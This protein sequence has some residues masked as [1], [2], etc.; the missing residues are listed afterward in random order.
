MINE[1]RSEEKTAIARN[2]LTKGYDNPVAPVF[3][4]MRVVKD[5]KPPFGAELRY[6]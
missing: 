5:G 3:V 4:Q 1:G 6:Y 2:M